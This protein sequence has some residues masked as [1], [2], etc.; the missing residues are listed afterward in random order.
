MVLDPIPQSLPIH[1]FGSQPQP[2]TSRLWVEALIVTVALV[3][4]MLRVA[5]RVAVC[6][7]MCVAV[8]CTMLQCV[9]V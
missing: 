2:P 3:Y 9:S 5:V 6:V 7:A 4:R 8:C 1:F